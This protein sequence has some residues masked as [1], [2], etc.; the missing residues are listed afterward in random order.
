M[1]LLAHLALILLFATFALACD[2]VDSAL[3]DNGTGD[4]GPNSQCTYHYGAATLESDFGVACTSDADCAHNECIMPG[5][6]GNITNEV[7]GFCSRGCDC[8]NSDDAKLPE[9]EPYSCVYPGGCYVGQS[10]G[11]WRHAA[12]KCST[13]SDCTDID[14]RYTHCQNTSQLTVIED[15]TCG[16]L[17]DVCQAHAE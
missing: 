11:G 15:E 16:Q 14:P 2:T 12:P 10:Q 4:D 8:D 17:R 3:E 13:L 7:F 6:S 1:R 9:A 5:D